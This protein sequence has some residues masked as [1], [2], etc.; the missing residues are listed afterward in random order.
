MEILKPYRDRIDELDDRIVDLLAERL[1]IVRDVGALKAREGIPAVLPE[2]VEA[3]LTRTAA[4]AADSR[5]DPGLVRGL[6]AAL[7]EYCC[8][9][10]EDI[11]EGYDRDRA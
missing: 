10:E 11:I 6:Y 9:L 7:V 4:R 3:V 5:L 1:E 8:E 2:R